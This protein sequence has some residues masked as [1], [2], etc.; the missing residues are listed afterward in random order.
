M[1]CRASSKF[2]QDVSIRTSST[3]ASK[4]FGHSSSDSSTSCR[5]F[6]LRPWISF[7]AAMA[8]VRFSIAE[9][10]S[11]WRVSIEL[12][13]RQA[14]KLR[15]SMERAKAMSQRACEG[16]L[17]CR[18]MRARL[19]KATEEGL[20]RMVWLRMRS[21]SSSLFSQKSRV[22][23]WKHFYDYIVRNI[24]IISCLTKTLV[25]LGVFKSWMEHMDNMKMGEYSV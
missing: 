25:A 2:P 7:S 23:V 24:K 3:K 5:Y 15:G 1:T 18:W 4:L 12:R 14:A 11:C 17:R 8:Q 22:A 16:W 10:R 13:L 20:R 9:E 19:L 6:V 21:A